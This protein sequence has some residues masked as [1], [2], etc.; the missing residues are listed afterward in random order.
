MFL[1][2]H[3]HTVALFCDVCAQSSQP[4]FV[5]YSHSEFDN[6]E[7]YG[8]TTWHAHL[9]RYTQGVK[10]EGLMRSE[11]HLRSPAVQRCEPP[12]H[13][14]LLSNR[15]F[16]GIEDVQPDTPDA[17]QGTA[18][19]KVSEAVELCSGAAC[20]IS[21]SF[22]E[23]E[24][25]CKRGAHKTASPPHLRTFHY[26]REPGVHPHHFILSLWFSFFAPPVPYGA[27]PLHLWSPSVNQVSWGIQ[28]A[29]LCNFINS[30]RF[31]ELER[32]CMWR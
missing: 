9:M 10:K 30:V 29:K 8:S 1:H 15:R 5:L 31:A 32:S 6:K 26:R 24:R 19:A 2:S 18:G 27:Q 4:F 16:D 14:H 17:P 25:G 21:F 28:G 20:A 13:V 23:L 22:A 11:M 12:H 3:H 7:D